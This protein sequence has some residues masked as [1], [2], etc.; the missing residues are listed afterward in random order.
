MEKMTD[1][2]IQQFDFKGRMF[3]PLQQGQM[4]KI[5]IIDKDIFGKIKYEAVLNVDYS[6]LTDID[7]QLNN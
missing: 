6:M 2:L 1:E 5:V 3:V 7:T 4:Q